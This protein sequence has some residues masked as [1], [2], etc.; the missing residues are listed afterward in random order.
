M[1]IISFFLF[2]ACYFFCFSKQRINLGVSIFFFT[3]VFLYE[4]FGAYF[5]T[6]SPNLH[7]NAWI[8]LCGL[9]Y[10]YFYFSSFLFFAR[11][12]LSGLLLHSLVMVCISFTKIIF[13]LHPLILLYPYAERLLPATESTFI[14]LFM[15]FF[16]SGVLFCRCSLSSRIVCVIFLFIFF[17]ISNSQ[18]K[19]SKKVDIKIAIVQIGLYFEKG[20]STTKFFDELM[21]FLNTHQEVNAIVF[22]ENN[23]FSYKTQYNKEMSERLLSAIKQNRLHHKFH[24]FLSFSGYRDFNNIITL[25]QYDNIRKINQKKILIPFVE[26]PGLFNSLSALA[27]EFYSVDKHHRNTIFN[28]MNSSVSTYICYDALF[29]DTDNKPGDILL[30]QSNY[31]LLDKGYGFERLQHIATYL[32]KFINGLQSKIVINIQN[33]GGTVVIFNGWHIDNNIYKMSKTEPFFVID[34][35]KL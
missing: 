28:I 18:V 1:L 17:L 9:L 22:S 33:T 29:P 26:K 25:Y 32:A 16:W 19:E 24:F 11:F 6:L 23:F 30:I 31:A 35:G 8:L 34:T 3:I 27:S 2:F 10:F 15:L 12:G 21:N 14:N 5:F 4:I 13:P 7:I 20:G